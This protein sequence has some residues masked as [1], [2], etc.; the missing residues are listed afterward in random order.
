MRDPGV[1][2]TGDQGGP[3]GYRQSD[4]SYDLKEGCRIGR[5]HQNRLPVVQKDARSSQTLPYPDGWRCGSHCDSGR[6]DG[7]RGMLLEP[8]S[9]RASTP[10]CRL[11]GSGIAG[12][13]GTAEP[14]A[15]DPD[16]SLALTLSPMGPAPAPTCTRPASS[17]PSVP[18][19]HGR[20]LR[21]MRMM[22]SGRGT[23]LGAWSASG[24]VLPLSAGLWP[25]SFARLGP[26]ASASPWRGGE[27][28]LA[29]HP[30]CTGLQTP[31]IPR[32]DA[33]LGGAD[34]LRQLPGQAP[35]RMGGPG[36]WPPLHH[37]CRYP[38]SLDRS[39]LPAACDSLPPPMS[40][41]APAGLKEAILEPRAGPYLSKTG[42]AQR[43]LE[44]PT[45]RRSALL[46]ASLFPA[47]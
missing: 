38:G 17:S 47:R 40:D 35:G 45:P 20:P 21:V 5:R 12:T 30:D 23:L 3:G 43:L 7:G 34:S 25:R 6:A 37:H 14:Q 46:P 11:Q 31:K 22:A 27:V 24:D 16:V 41:H 9:G 8:S 4:E 36:A 15:L 2:R 26:M 10:Y 19:V 44:L 28:D 42:T 29:E 32:V 33:A 1:K 18:A 39:S 13:R